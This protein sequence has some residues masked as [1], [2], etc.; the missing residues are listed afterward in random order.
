MFQRKPTAKDREVAAAFLANYT[1][2][3]AGMHRLAEKAKVAWGR[4]RPRAL[5]ASNEYLYLD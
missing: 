5:L 3:L 1:A 4:A 2:A